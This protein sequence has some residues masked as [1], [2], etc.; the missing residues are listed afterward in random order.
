MWEVIEGDCLEMLRGIGA[1]TVDCVVTSPPYWGLR[2]YGVDGQLGLEATPGEYV[3]HLV[4][5]LREVRRVLKTDG[6]CW[7]VL[8][9]SYAGGGG[10]SAEAP[11]SGESKSGKYG[12]LG[13]LKPGGIKPQGVIK[14]K[15]L[16]GIPWRVAFA[17]QADGWWLRQDVIEEVELYCPCGCGYILEER[18]WR[19]SQDRDMIWNK[20]NPM[21]ESV[22]DRCTKSHEYVFLL[23]KSARYWY[24][25]AAIAEPSV[26]CDVRRPYGSQGSWDMDGRPNEQWHGGEPRSYKG[27][28][29]NLGKTAEHQLNRSSDRP[30]T[31]GKWSQQDPHSSGRRIVENVKGARAEGAPHET[32]FGEMRNK[33]SVWPIATRRWP[34]AHFA[35]FPE[36]LVEPCIRAGC[37]PGGV[38]LDPFCG[39]GTT[40]VVAFREARDFI[41]IELNPEYCEMARQRIGWAELAGRQMEL[42]A[43]ETGDAGDL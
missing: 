5:V 8:G 43:K 7:I 13:A 30:R 9:D 28:R 10:F 24:D 2:N 33:R 21:P 15:D 37:R 1:E 16:V 12:N 23:T 22:R 26:T 4:A 42:G 27:S 6:T 20:P 36:A 11:S 31:N 25:A 17:L 39:S 41:G 38:V 35:V 34:G 3:G 19:W 29:F 14:P 40:G 32:P 18:I